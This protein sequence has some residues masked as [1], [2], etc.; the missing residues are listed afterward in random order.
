MMNGF[1]SVR[2]AMKAS[3]ISRASIYR[4]IKPR[5]H[6]RCVEKAKVR[7]KSDFRGRRFVSRSDLLRHI[8][9]EN[10]RPLAPR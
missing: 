7:S 2:E 8:R 3:G 10:A 6:G 5:R 4:L 1:I 9:S